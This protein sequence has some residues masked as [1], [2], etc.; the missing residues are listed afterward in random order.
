MNYTLSIDSL[1]KLS[2]LYPFLPLLKESLG[3]DPEWVLDLSC[4]TG[5]VSFILSQYVKPKQLICADYHF[6]NLYMARKY[7]V[8]DA[9]FI[10]LDAKDSLPFNDAFFSSIVMMD[11]FHYIR[12][13]ASVAREMERVISPRGILLL[14]HLHNSLNYNSAAGHPLSPTGW[15]NLFSKLP[16][17]ILSE[18]NIIESFI[19]D[20]RIDLSKNA[21]ESDLKSANAIILLGTKNDSYLQGNIGKFNRSLTEDSKLI[22]NPLYN[23]KHEGDQIIFQR[24]FPDE[25][26][27]KDYPLTEKYLPEGYIM[28]EKFAKLLKGR[29]LDLDG[30]HLSRDDLAIIEDLIEKFVII[31]VPEN[32]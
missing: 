7:F 16:I 10:C 30:A 14:L 19:L 25:L 21:S 20:T 22:I 32:F 27:R 8:P 31:N 18:K 13:K 29:T 17:K 4:G 2:G 26:F 6:K 9:S 24:T 11:A 28:T 3:E 5:H 15:K 1:Q 12:S 23:I